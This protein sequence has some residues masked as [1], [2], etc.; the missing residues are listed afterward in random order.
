MVINIGNPTLFLF[1]MTSK[2]IPYSR[3]TIDDSDIQAV[4]DV[5]KSDFLS[6]GSSIRAFEAALR[7]YLNVKHAIV[8]SNGTS[9]LHLSYLA[10][11]LQSATVFTTPI[12][13]AATSNMLHAV[14]AKICFVDVDPVTGIMSTEMLEK[15]LEAEPPSVKKAIV[16]VSLQGIA[17]DLPVIHGLAEKYRATVIEDAAHS[18]GGTYIFEG[19]TYK[20]ASCVHTDLATLSFHPLK[21]ITCGEG[22]AVVT[23]NDRLAERVRLFLNHGLQ[24]QPNTYVRKQKLWG[25]NDRMS[26]LQAALG[27]SQL[28]RIDAFVEKRRAI[29]RYY[30]ERLSKEPYASHLTCVPYHEGSSYHLFVVHFK[31]R[32]KRDFAYQKLKENG[33]ETGVHYL[34]LYEYQGYRE[35][36]GELSLHG[37]D[38]YARG[39]LS[40]PI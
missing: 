9:A 29:A 25:Y 15:A 24:S 31:D 22:G 17:A 39:C 37:A 18:F 28:K 40:L 36:L 8:C 12:T 5:L 16:P 35:L 38:A 26:E 34:P 23:N 2:H 4:T 14:G 10:S 13:F 21:T 6:Q 1:H 19:K 30:S 33:V 32:Q 27:L 20:S 3:Q 7:D 11:E